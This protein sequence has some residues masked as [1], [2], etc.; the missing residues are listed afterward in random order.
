MS[1]QYQT[2]PKPSSIDA[3]KPLSEFAVQLDIE[4]IKDL[5]IDGLLAF[6]R[7]AN[8]LAAAQI[9]LQSNA[10]LEKPLVADDIKPR[11][12]G[13]LVFDSSAALLAEL[14]RLTWI[15]FRVLFRS[16]G[17]L[18]RPQLGLRPLQLPDHSSCEARRGRPDALR[19]WPWPIGT[20]TH[21]HVLPTASAYYALLCSADLR[22][23]W[24]VIH[25]KRLS[26]G[27]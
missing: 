14:P 9:F 3:S 11:L 7:V 4:S 27:A 10:L 21:E 8:Y 12:L 26:S 17:N 20:S 19:R 22:S 16:L 23:Q 1:D 2:P 5:D 13:M 24:W 18:P 6:Q 15:S 25:C